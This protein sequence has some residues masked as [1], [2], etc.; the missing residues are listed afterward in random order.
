[1]HIFRST[2]WY[3]GLFGDSHSDYFLGVKV[4]SQSIISNRTSQCMVYFITIFPFLFQHKCK[5]QGFLDGALHVHIPC[6]MEPHPKLMYRTQWSS[7]FKAR[8]LKIMKTAL[9]TFLHKTLNICPHVEGRDLKM[10]IIQGIFHFISIYVHFETIT[11]FIVNWFFL[12]IWI[13]P[14]NHIYCPLSSI[15][16][17]CILL[18]ICYG[19]WGIWQKNY[20]KIYTN[21]K[22]CNC[23]PIR[24]MGKWFFL[25]RNRFFV[26]IWRYETVNFDTF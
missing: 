3:Y 12:K 22:W 23:H 11:S 25:S 15:I 24:C 16:I 6:P 7:N 17:F 10:R 13:R 20:N 5:Y 4:T 26:K 9:G 18:G 1:M 21:I 8:F 2:L 14:L 19:F